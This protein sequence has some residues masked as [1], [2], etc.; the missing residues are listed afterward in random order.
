M[1]PRDKIALEVLGQNQGP[2]FT[3]VAYLAK[4]LDT[5][6]QGWPAGLHALAAVVL[7]TQESRKLTFGAPTVIGL[8]HDFK[9][10]LSHKSMTL[11]S[12]CIQ[13]IHVTLLKSPEFSF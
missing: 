7:L 8:P 2:S 9:D 11:L 1:L 13:L 3:P 4:Q 12:P 10:L 5:T 6:T